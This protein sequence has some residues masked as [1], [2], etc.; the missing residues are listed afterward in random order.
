MTA[1]EVVGDL[2][3]DPATGSLWNPAVAPV[4]PPPYRVI[5]TP[6]PEQV[7]PLHQRLIGQ[8]VEGRGTLPRSCLAEYGYQPRYTVTVGGVSITV[9][10][11]ELTLVPQTPRPPAV[12]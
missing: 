1:F 5:Y 4:D 9:L 6:D 7:G 2:L 11:Q 10:A 3:Y 8:E 12:P